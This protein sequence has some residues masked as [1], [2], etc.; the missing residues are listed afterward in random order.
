M[1]I[2]HLKYLRCPRT[3]KQLILKNEI[4]E[5][6]RAK[7]GILLEPSSGAEYPIV[8]FIPRFVPVENYASG[9][10]FQWNLH[11]KTQFDDYSHINVSEKR[12]YEETRWEK[13]LQGQLILEVG[14]GSGRFTTVAL[15]TSALVVSLDYSNAVEANYKSNGHLDNLLLVQ[16][17]VYEMPFEEGYFD[18]VLCI[19]VLQHT[20]DPKKSFLAIVDYLRSGGQIVTD[21][22]RKSFI[23]YY[24]N[25]KYLVRLFTKGGNAERLYKRVVN[26]VNFMWPL[27]RVVRVIDPRISHRFCVVDHSRLLPDAPDSLIKEWAY[28]DTFDMLAPMYDFPE[29]IREFRQWHIE[30]GL[31]D[32][33]VHPG[34]NG[35]EGRATKQ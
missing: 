7:T 4:L 22:Y 23:K 35:I 34:H 3:K 25:P 18:K 8:N 20:P 29:T 21:I 13:N 15:K 11:N 19:G 14:S 28:L 30:A 24:V 1:K 2:E 5:K 33:D 10:G 12:F 9:F 16:A 32:I 26:W 31:K 17:S 6:G 27:A